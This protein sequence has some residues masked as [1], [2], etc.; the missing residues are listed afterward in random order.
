MPTSSQPPPKTLYQCGLS[1]EQAEKL[2]ILLGDRG[3]TFTPRPYTLYFAQKEKLTMAVY[4]KGPKLVLQGKG[5]E[6]FVQF[7]LEPEI[8]GEARLGYEEV[9]NPRD[10]RPALRHR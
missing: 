9:L 3:W 7:T 8:L 2:R 1:P 4:E 10:V 5:T 6:E